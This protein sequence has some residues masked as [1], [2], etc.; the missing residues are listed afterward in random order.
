MFDFSL[1]LLQFIH[2]LEHR[3]RSHKKVHIVHLMPYFFNGLNFYEEFNFD[4]ILMYPGLLA[5]VI[6]NSSSTPSKLSFINNGLK[7]L[8]ICCKFTL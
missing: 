6:D 7:Y 5:A 3:V 4:T 2:I 8:G 1:G